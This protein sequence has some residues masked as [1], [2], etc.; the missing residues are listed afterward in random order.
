MELLIYVGRTSSSCRDRPILRVENSPLEEGRSP[1]QTS[2]A[3]AIG[4]HPTSAVACFGRTARR[5]EHR[6]YGPSEVTGIYFTTKLTYRSSA[7]INDRLSGA[8][9][10]TCPPVKRQSQVAAATAFPLPL[11][12]PPT[13]PTPA[14][15]RHRG[16]LPLS[17]TPS[18]ARSCLRGGSKR[19][20]RWPSL[21]LRFACRPQPDEQKRR[22]CLPRR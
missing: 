4:C 19:E 5:H 17:G 13:S 3:M 1:F 9:R 21:R 11:H 20:R 15:R 12:S 8:S 18:A 14:A 10:K 7:Q 22:P 16:L 2:G 6:A